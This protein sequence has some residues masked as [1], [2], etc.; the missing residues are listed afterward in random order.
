MCQE[1]AF[2]E[3]C[4]NPPGNT[5]LLPFR[6]MTRMRAVFR[7]P[8]RSSVSRRLGHSLARLPQPPSP[9]ARDCDQQLVIVAAAS[10]AVTG[11]RPR[12]AHHSRAPG[13]TG[14]ASA[15]ISTP[16]P[17]ASATCR[18]ASARP[19][20]RVHRRAGRPGLRHRVPQPRSRARAGGIVATHAASFA[21]AAL[22]ASPVPPPRRQ[23]SRS[24]RARHPAGRRFAS[25]P[26]AGGPRQPR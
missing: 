5:S 12:A 1:S 8:R 14:S 16:H 18:S 11:S 23:P 17:L 10:A 26:V 4:S 15:S 7:Q 25:T 21:A 20:L 9:R 22:A 6:R 3:K 13:S 24:R 2:T 19:S